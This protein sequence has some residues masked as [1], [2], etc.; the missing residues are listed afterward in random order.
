MYG[1]E[2]EAF[3]SEDWERLLESVKRDLTF[4]EEVKSE[5]G[6]DSSQTEFNS[7]STSFDSVVVSFILSIDEY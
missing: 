2:S 1:L 5:F 4:P 7:I 6:Y 3:N